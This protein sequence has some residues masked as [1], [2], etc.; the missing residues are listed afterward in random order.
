[1]DK[2]ITLGTIIFTWVRVALASNDKL[3][4]FVANIEETDK[5]YQ[6]ATALNA[7]LQTTN[8]ALVEMIKVMYYVFL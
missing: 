8:M 5:K 3:R 2:T 4:M 1:M 7:Q 6:E